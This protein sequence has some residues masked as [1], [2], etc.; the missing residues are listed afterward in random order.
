MW[1]GETDERSRRRRWL[2]NLPQRAARTGFGATRD[3]RRQGGNCLYYSEYP[4]TQE[5]LDTCVPDSGRRTVAG[6]Q[7]EHRSSRWKSCSA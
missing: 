5:M 6:S 3:S 2:V 7:A 1:S 4:V